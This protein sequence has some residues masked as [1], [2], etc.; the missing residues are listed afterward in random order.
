MAAR[1]GYSDRTWSA[2][3][4]GGSSGK[5]ERGSAFP[6]AFVQTNQ[7]RQSGVITVSVLAHITPHEVPPGLLLLAL[8][9]LLGVIATWSVL[10]LIRR[11]VKRD[12]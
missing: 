3:Q 11:P 7:P 10:G 9:F 1:I 4:L 2:V 8:G 6:V 12:P 5:M